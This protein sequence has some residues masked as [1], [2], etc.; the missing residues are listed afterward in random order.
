M[1]K[2]LLALLL[3]ILF[4]SPVW[5]Q[6]NPNPLGPD[7]YYLPDPHSGLRWSDGFGLF[8]SFYAPPVMSTESRYSASIY[9]SDIDNYLDV[10]SH[11][12]KIGTFFFLGG[13]P[14]LNNVNNTSYITGY[15]FKDYAISFGFAKTINCSYLGIYYGGSLV[16][17]SGGESHK[18]PGSND[19]DYID[20]QWRNKLA[21]LFS[22]PYIGALRFD[23]ILDTGVVKDKIDNDEYSKERVSAPSLALTWGGI[24]LFGM[25]PYIT[26]GYKFP[27][28]QIMGRD[29]PL[30][31]YR[32]ATYTT[33]SYIGIQTGLN[34]DFKKNSSLRSDLS[35]VLA[36]PDR[37]KGDP[38]MIVGVGTPPVDPYKKGGGLGIGLRT[39]YE[40][41]FTF[42]KFSFGLRPGLVLAYRNISG[43][44]TETGIANGPTDHYF[45]VWTGTDLGIEFK[46]SSKIAIYT[47][48]SLQLFDFVYNRYSDGKD[49]DAF[50]IF[51]GIQGD[52]TRWAYSQKWDGTP[53]TNYLGF[54]LTITPNSH[55]EIGTGLNTILD[56]FF[57]VDLVNMSV[58]AGEFFDDRK[59]YNVGSWMMGLFRGIKFD[60]TVSYKF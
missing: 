14:A 37:Y 1:K 22:S 58:S 17:Y 40:K 23:M 36:L 13:Y 2:I 54:G 5:A 53:V 26:L 30:T 46:A 51:D 60:L 32:E 43:R 42:G 33:G 29:I 11:D 3:S 45:E 47:G 20:T 38:E 55:L 19:E 34:Y 25:D 21:L 59:E 12:P 15:G 57:V 16:Y 7:W 44:T 6:L 8:D 48:I 28:K 4:F 52:T 56:R 49:K 41:G 18:S 39:A 24:K 9:D 27:E 50:W 31:G 10:N 35:F